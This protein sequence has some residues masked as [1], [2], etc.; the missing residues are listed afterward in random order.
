MKRNERPRDL[1][2]QMMT[3]MRTRL[4]VPVTILLLFSGLTWAMPSYGLT[5]IKSNSVGD[6]LLAITTVL[7]ATSYVQ[8]Q[9]PTLADTILFNN[10]ISAATTYRVSN[11]TNSA[12]NLSNGVLNVGGLR[13]V[14][15]GGA[16]TIQNGNNQNQTINLGAQGIDMSLATQN[17]T[18]SNATGGAV[19]LATAAAQTWK[20]ANVRTLTIGGPIALGHNVSLEYYG[21]NT[22]GTAG[23]VTLGSTTTGI[24]GVGNLNVTGMVGGSGGA[25]NLLGNNNTWTGALTVSGGAQVN[26]DQGAAGQNKLADAATVTLNRGTLNFQNTSAGTEVIGGLSLGLG[27]NQVLRGTGTGVLQAGAISRSTTGAALNVG[28]IGTTAGSSYLTTTSLNTNLILGGWA[29]A[30]NGTTDTNFVKNATN[31]ANGAV[32]AASGTDYTTQ[33]TMSS[34]TN[35][36][37]NILINGTAV[38]NAGASRTINS[39]KIAHTTATT[40]VTVDMGAGLTLTVN[41]GLNGGGI[42]RN[43]N[44]ATTIGNA[45]IGGRF[46]TSGGND[47]T[48]DTLYLW[49]SQNTMSV[50]AVVQN[51]GAGALTLFSGG[52]GTVAIN[53]A[54]TYT[55]GT[56]IAAGTM[57]LGNNNAASDT[58][59]LG[60]GPVTNYGTLVIDKVAA[61]SAANGTIAN[62]ISGTGNLT[63][64]RGVITLSGSN[65]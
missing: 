13:V 2:Q 23:I 3:T 63:I 28:N 47:A 56:V 43:Q 41:D 9:A 37:Q 61:V 25:V 32:I 27:L 62:N 30:I 40:A 34:W 12:V 50:N 64:N 19:T 29:V 65:T 46:L 58:A 5:L 31:A 17:L 48:A 7:P 6:T 33:N 21:G 14:N 53:A 10:T 4:R 36:A 51:N 11:V 52:A 8:N 26:L 59:S 35:P 42:I 55:G 16:I 22:G 38:A 39:L 45:T 1:S 60:T 18:I 57:N 15:P 49:N 44:A 54:N 20:V 24:S